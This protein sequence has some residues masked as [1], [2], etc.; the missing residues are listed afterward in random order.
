MTWLQDSLI[1]KGASLDFFGPSEA[2]VQLPLCV[3]RRLRLVGRLIG[4]RLHLRLPPRVFSSA[5]ALLRTGYFATIT[6]DAVV[7]DQFLAQI[8]HPFQL[9]RGV[10]RPG[11]AGR[12][13]G[14]S[15]ESPSATSVMDIVTALV[16][17][18]VVGLAV[19]VLALLAKQKG[20]RHGQGI[21][22]RNLPLYL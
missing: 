1:N 13:G 15:A 9:L 12:A 20:H 19:Y 5:S 18:G 17:G 3:S 10:S 16:M 11:S 21:L 4:S 2:V 14:T 7:V 8:N 6:D 22:G